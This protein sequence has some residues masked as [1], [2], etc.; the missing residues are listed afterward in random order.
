[1]LSPDA[2]CP[3]SLELLTYPY[4][5]LHLSVQLKLVTILH[6]AR[7]F[8]WAS[9]N[10]PESALFGPPR[11]APGKEHCVN[12]LRFLEHLCQPN[13]ALTCKNLMGPRQEE[14]REQRSQSR[15]VELKYSSSLQSEGLTSPRSEQDEEPS[16][17]LSYPDGHASHERLGL[18]FWSWKKP[19]GH[20]EHVWPVAA[21]NFPLSLLDVI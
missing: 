17:M 13:F 15:R 16:R 4:S 20:S 12:F 10:L 18:V 11:H 1:M 8:P 14:P 5:S 19:A 9:R 2:H 3:Q 7:S 21:L 6:W